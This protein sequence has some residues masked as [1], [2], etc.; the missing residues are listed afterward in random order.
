MSFPQELSD[1]IIDEAS[2]IPGKEESTRALTSLSLVS[3]AFRERAHGHLFASITFDGSARAMEAAQNLL[4]LLE[5]DHDTD[6]LGLASKIT[7]FA[8]SIPQSGA[9][10]LVMILNKLFIAEGRLCSLH[11]AFLSPYSWPYL[12]ENLVRA[13]FEV[14]HRPRL[15][16]LSID[17]L[18]NIPRNFLQHSFVKRLTLD[19]VSVSDSQLPEFWFAG[20]ARQGHCEAVLLEYLNVSVEKRILPLLTTSPQFDP[21]TVFSCLQELHFHDI[22][23]DTDLRAQL[24]EVLSGCQGQLGILKVWLG[25]PRPNVST[26]RKP[27]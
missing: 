3:T 12:P 17:W 20:V 21:K 8:C 1:M 26:D 10:P 13:I 6:T 2:K 15:A 9:G 4:G 27:P 25:L 5:V 16:T 14:C 18:Y 23:E 11:L 19:F 24:S 7:S 22:F